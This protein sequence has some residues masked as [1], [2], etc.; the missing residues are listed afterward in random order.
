MQKHTH[1]FSFLY[2]N[3][4]VRWLNST[5]ARILKHSIFFS[6]RFCC[7]FC[8]RFS[9][10][11]T[12][13][14]KIENELFKKSCTHKHFWLVS[15]N[16]IHN[17]HTIACHTSQTFFADFP[18]RNFFNCSHGF[19]YERY[20]WNVWLCGQVQG[21]QRCSGVKKWKPVRNMQKNAERK[22]RVKCVSVAQT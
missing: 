13:S 7:C 22:K 17:Y 8:V 14:R 15:T 12:I 21:Q 1:T 20:I 18:I 2:G 10:I 4:C 11:C 19:G 9:S 5:Y 16:R 6:V 3:R